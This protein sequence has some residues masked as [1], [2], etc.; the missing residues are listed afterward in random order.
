MTRA[1]A[2][3]LIER[4]AATD[5]KSVIGDFDV[6]SVHDPSAVIALHRGTEFIGGSTVVCYG[7]AAGVIG[8]FTL[9]VDRRRGSMGRVLWHDRVHCL[10]GRQ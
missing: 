9:R 10:R 2:G 1:E 8:L 3:E 7:T 4:V 5:W 6:V